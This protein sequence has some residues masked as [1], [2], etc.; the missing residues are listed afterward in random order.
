MDD[1]GATD[2]R[3]T[4]AR[5]RQL[6]LAAAIAAVLTFFTIRAMSGPAPNGD[7]VGA[8]TRPLLAV[9]VFVVLT[10][11]SHAVLARARRR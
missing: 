11:A 6:A 1:L 10:A 7:P 2:L 5:L 3:N 9:F 4:R 8:S